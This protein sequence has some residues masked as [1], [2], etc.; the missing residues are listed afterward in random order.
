MS[1]SWLDQISAKHGTLFEEEEE[2]EANDEPVSIEKDS[3][4]EEEIK[5]DEVV[6]TVVGD[7]GVQKEEKKIVYDGPTTKETSIFV[8]SVDKVV[9]AEEKAYVTALMTLR[10]SLSSALDIASRPLTNSG[11][12]GKSSHDSRSK[13]ATLRQKILSIPIPHSN[14]GENTKI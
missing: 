4:K 2:E 13:F 3:S 6:E 1:N 14:V 8:K 5:T 10:S 9:K 11:A 7:E 12:L